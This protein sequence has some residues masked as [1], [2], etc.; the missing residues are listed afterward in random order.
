MY[1]F[2][3]NTSFDN[4]SFWKTESG[5]IL[6]TSPPII[7]YWSHQQSIS[8][9]DFCWQSFALIFNS[10]FSMVLLTLILR[11]TISVDNFKRI[12]GYLKPLYEFAFSAFGWRCKLNWISSFI[13]IIE[14]K[15]FLRAYALATTRVIIRWRKNM[16]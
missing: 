4:V 15:R 16:K 9:C 8:K 11:Y 12:M 1:H 3:F 5:P 14:R 7:C 2:I 13:V 6:K 10:C